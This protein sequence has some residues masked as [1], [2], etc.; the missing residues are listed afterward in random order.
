MV[1]A[2]QATDRLTAVRKGVFIVE[3]RARFLEQSG[4]TF[5]IEPV[6]SLDAIHLIVASWLKETRPSLAIASLDDRVRDNASALGITV[7]P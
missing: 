1:D 7:L 5:P 2:V 4:R 3:L 6:R